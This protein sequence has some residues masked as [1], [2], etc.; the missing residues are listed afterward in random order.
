[1][2]RHEML[3][4]HKPY[5]FFL[6]SISQIFYIN[7]LILQFLNVYNKNNSLVQE[8]HFAFFAAYLSPSLPFSLNHLHYIFQIL[9]LVN[10]MD[11]SHKLHYSQ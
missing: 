11:I 4:L 1:M 10:N 9:G 2:N 5:D 8:V 7:E 6:Q 3:R